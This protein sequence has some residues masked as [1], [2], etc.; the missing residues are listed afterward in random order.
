MSVKTA[1]M[2]WRMV[3]QESAPVIAVFVVTVLW[4]NGQVKIAILRV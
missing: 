2:V 4:K 1:M 3:N